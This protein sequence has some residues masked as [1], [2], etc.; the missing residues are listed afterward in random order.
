[1][2]APEHPASCEGAA[3]VRMARERGKAKELEMQDW[4][5]ANMRTLDP[6]AVKAAAERMLGVKDF[7]TEYANAPGGGTLAA[8]AVCA[9]S[10]RSASNVLGTAGSTIPCGLPDQ[11]HAP[12][13]SGRPE[14]STPVARSPPNEPTS[15]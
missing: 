11:P 12:S 5:F 6:D 9:G 1:M 3:A 2:G 15:T 13:I 8:P 7:T 10:L 4:L 14:V